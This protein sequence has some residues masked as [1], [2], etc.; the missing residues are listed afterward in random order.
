MHGTGFIALKW[1]RFYNYSVWNRF[2]IMHVIMADSLIH[3]N[4]LVEG[5]RW[6]NELQ[7][8][9]RRYY[10]ISWRK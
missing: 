1:N 3:Q 4:T 5:E 8:V 2:Q 7:K 9:S 6:G 10:T